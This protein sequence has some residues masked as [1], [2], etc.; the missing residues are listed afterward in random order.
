MARF[1]GPGAPLGRGRPDGRALAVVAIVAA[2]ITLLALVSGGRVLTADRLP[3]EPGRGDPTDQQT[4]TTTATTLVETTQDTEPRPPDRRIRETPDFLGWLIGLAVWLLAAVGVG[5]A[6]GALVVLLLRSD[7]ARA[8]RGLAVDPDAPIGP[9]DG[10]AEHDRTVMAESLAAGATHLEDADDP[11]AAIIACY[12]ALLDGLESCAQGRRPAETPDEHLERVLAALEVRAEP[13]RELT[14]LFGEARFS[15][16]VMTEAQR[17]RARTALASART[18]L[19]RVRP[20]P[21]A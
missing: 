6:I 20:E 11:R 1:D 2:C 10:E 4:S 3:A 8:R 13:L 12:A 21:V 16:H 15:D 5:L 18:D 14:T 7:W 17:D 19:D 9:T